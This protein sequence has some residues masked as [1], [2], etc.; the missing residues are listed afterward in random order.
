MIEKEKKNHFWDKEAKKPT[1]LTFILLFALALSLLIWGFVETFSSIHEIK[2]EI[3]Y[4]D[5]FMGEIDS[6]DTSEQINGNMGNEFTYEIRKGN[7]I[8]VNVIKFDSKETLTVKIYDN[9]ELVREG[10][11]G[12]KWSSVSLI[13]TVGE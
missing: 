9:G 1:K 10:S 6:Q 12:E 8:R 4:S 11:T 7:D 2:V 3:E 5:D 13:Y